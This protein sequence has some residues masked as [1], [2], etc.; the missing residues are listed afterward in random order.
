MRNNSQLRNNHAFL[1]TWKSMAL[2]D[3]RVTSRANKRS[4][5]GE[6]SSH[7][8][9]SFQGKRLTSQTKRVV[10]N[11]VEYFKREAKKSKGHP[12]IVEKVSKATGKM[13][14]LL[15]HML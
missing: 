4:R 14:I 3:S 11:M 12:N 10:M 5:R 9:H 7:E 6:S 8:K 13:V 1:V 2:L 15:K